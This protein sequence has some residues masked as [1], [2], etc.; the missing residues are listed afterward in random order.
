MYAIQRKYEESSRQYHA[1]QIAYWKGLFT[2]A[3]NHIHSTFSLP[4]LTSYH[5]CAAA[6]PS[7]SH[8]AN[9]SGLKTEE[10]LFRDW[11]NLNN[12][13]RFLSTSFPQ[14]SL[15]PIPFPTPYIDFR[16]HLIACIR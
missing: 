15:P 4:D 10:R 3:T 13:S 2:H 6:L 16:I 14:Y 9:V 12:G 5:K 7:P 11:R 1:E 8:Y